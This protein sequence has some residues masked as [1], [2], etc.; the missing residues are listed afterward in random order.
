MNFSISGSIFSENRPP[1]SFFGASASAE[2]PAEALATVR[3]S[4]VR[5]AFRLAALCGGALRTPLR[6]AGSHAPASSI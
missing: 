5:L 4:G 1:Q 2:L 6:A 3:A